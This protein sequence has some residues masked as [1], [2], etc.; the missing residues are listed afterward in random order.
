MTDWR[1]AG[2]KADV[3]RIRRLWT[4]PF[5]N[6]AKAVVRKR[7]AEVLVAAGGTTV[8]D[9]GGGGGSAAVFRDHGLRVISV[10]DGTMN[11][12][13]EAG[14][15]IRAARKRRAHECICAE[16]GVEARWGSAARF[17]HEADVAFLDFCG[18]WCESTRLAVEACRHMKAVA[19]TLTTGHD[20]YTKATTQRERQ[21]AYMAWVKDAYRPKTSRTRGIGQNI[22]QTPGRV[23]CE[24]KAPTGQPVWVLLVS[25]NA[26]PIRHL[27][28]SERLALDPK[29]LREQ[30]NTRAREKW[31]ADDIWRAKR[32]AYCNE[33]RRRNRKRMNELNRASYH[34]RK[35][36]DKAA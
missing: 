35:D 27:T 17:A 5:D 29:A 6:P 18:F 8:L 33:W 36:L 7:V 26:I 10:E 20:I 16:L 19:V 2:I 11:L 23:L 4:Q 32:K 9:L 30:A 12:E 31:A 13:D 21:L 24:Y 28:H 3:S 14:R 22:R 25:T 34:R 15:P 1:E